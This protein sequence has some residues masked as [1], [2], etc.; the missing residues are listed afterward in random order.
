[1]TARGDFFLAAAAA[2]AS[3]LA[4]LNAALLF[5]LGVID[6]PIVVLLGRGRGF[7]AAL[8]DRVILIP[9][10]VLGVVSGRTSRA[11]DALRVGVTGA[12]ARDGVLGGAS[13][14]RRAAGAVDPV[15]TVRDTGGLPDP[16]NEDG[17][18]APPSFCNALNAELLF[19]LGVTVGG[20]TLATLIVSR[21]L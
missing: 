15:E 16:R 11:D 6:G 8:G 9:F 4:A 17:G 7:P 14:C 1:L 2:S 10:S 18:V 3:I 12:G 13:D 19:N 21:L 5:V 20:L